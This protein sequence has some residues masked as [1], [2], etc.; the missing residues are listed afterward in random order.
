MDTHITSEN[1]KLPTD[2]LYYDARPPLGVSPAGEHPVAAA[3]GKWGIFHSPKPYKI[4]ATA[5]VPSGSDKPF[6]VHV[7]SCS[8]LGDGFLIMGV[9][10]G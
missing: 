8:P 6:D 10:G 3:K 5:T 9:I 4:G 7:K 1:T 2:V